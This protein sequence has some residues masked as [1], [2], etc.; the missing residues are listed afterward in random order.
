[1]L[2]QKNMM[3]MTGLV[4]YVCVVFIL[5]GV[6]NDFKLR[7]LK[8]ISYISVHEIPTTFTHRCLTKVSLKGQVSW[9]VQYKMPVPHVEVHSFLSVLAIL[10]ECTWR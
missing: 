1:M 4:Q 7:I 5:K 10:A 9:C 3:Q 6:F 8:S 2:L